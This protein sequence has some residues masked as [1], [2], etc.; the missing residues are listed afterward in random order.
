MII[1][2]R[3]MIERSTAFEPG[4]SEQGQELPHRLHVVRVAE[5]DHVAKVPVEE[6]RHQLRRREP[7]PTGERLQILAVVADRLILVR[8]N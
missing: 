1:G 8:R 6:H 7:A 3:K 4:F 5:P 2:T